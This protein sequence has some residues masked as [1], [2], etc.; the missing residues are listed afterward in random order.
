MEKIET[1]FTKADTAFSFAMLVCGFL[2]FNLI[3]LFTLGAGITVFALVVCAVSFLYMQKSGVRQNAGSLLCLGLL[4]LSAAQF[5]LFDDPFIKSLNFMF[6]SVL[7]IYWICL[8]TGRR[9]DN[10]LSAYIIGDAIKQGIV[11]P[12]SNF[13]CCFS[14]LKQPFLKQKKGKSLLAALLWILIFMPLLLAVTGL[15]ISADP[16]FENFAGWFFDIISF[17]KVA[18]YISQ[19]ILGIPVAFYLYGSIYGNVKGRHSERFTKET[20]DNGARAVRIAPKLTIYSALACFCIIYLA[21]FA[22]QAV[23]LF[24]AFGGSLPEAFTYAEYARRGFFE[25]CAVAGINLAVLLISRLTI[26]REAYEAP[27]VLRAGMLAVSLFTIML[28][29]TALSKM[30]MYIEVYGLTQPRLF[31]SWFM[32]LLLLVFVLIS[33]R[34]FKRFNSAKAMIIGFVI[35]FMVLLYGNSD[36][37]I[38]KYNIGRY[39]AGTLK[40]LDIYALY[41]LSDAAVPYAY[42]FYLRSGDND[43]RQELEKYLFHRNYRMAEA[44]D[45]NKDFRNFNLQR[46]KADEVRARLSDG[47][48]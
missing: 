25:L 35:M 27:K 24:S 6:L 44:G 13:G 26:K 28:I 14:G 41:E 43:M 21:F 10:K 37:F 12:F 9:L 32:V 36:G 1:V 30:A 15:L 18:P 46:A 34:Q 23:Y 17:D 20:A 19:F 7:F 45:M 31:T 38:A 48:V 5:S 2:Y 3:N 39:E 16:A 8:S 47:D 22:V 33:A 29:A 40:T 42:E 4:V 11:M